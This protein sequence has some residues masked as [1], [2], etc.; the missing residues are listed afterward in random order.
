[1]IELGGFEEALEF[2]ERLHILWSSSGALGLN[3]GW[4]IQERYT[5][6]ERIRRDSVGSRLI[7]TTHASYFRKKID[8]PQV[9]FEGED[10]S[11]M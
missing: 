11:V 1:M 6:P 4:K 10:R 9:S 5:P 7:V 2:I 8:C 3:E